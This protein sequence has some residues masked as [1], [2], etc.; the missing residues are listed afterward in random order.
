MCTFLEKYSHSLKKSLMEK[1]SKPTIESREQ[2]SDRLSS[3]LYFTIAKI[4]KRTVGLFYA[5]MMS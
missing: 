3:S 4:K 5:P 2:Q 1:V